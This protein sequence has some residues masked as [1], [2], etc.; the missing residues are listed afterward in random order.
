MLYLYLA[1]PM[2]HY[3]LR[4]FTRLFKS[5]PAKFKSLFSRYIRRLYSHSQST[6]ALPGNLVSSEEWLHACAKSAL[7]VAYL[8]VHACMCMSCACLHVVICTGCFWKYWHI[9]FRFLRYL[10]YI[11]AHFRYTRRKKDFWKFV[12]Q[13]AWFVSLGYITVR[14]KKQRRNIF[15]FKQNPAF[16]REGVSEPVLRMKPC[17]PGTLAFTLLWNTLED[18]VLASPRSRFRGE[19][20]K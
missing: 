15:T 16:R 4:W 9:C 2:L 19:W 12:W 3:N 5:D 8:R 18:D 10:M 17:L 20:N 13:H 14:R 7:H 1:T 11:K 6:L